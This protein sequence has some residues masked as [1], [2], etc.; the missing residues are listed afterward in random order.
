MSHWGRISVGPW[1]Y[2]DMGNWGPL[3][4][5]GAESGVRASFTHN[6]ICSAGAHEAP[7]PLM[8]VFVERE[9]S[10]VYPVKLRLPSYSS[11]ARLK[12]S[13]SIQ[14]TQRLSLL[15]GWRQCWT[16]LE[17]GFRAPGT[18]LPL[19]AK[20]TFPEAALRAP[21][22]QSPQWHLPG[23]CLPGV[24]LISC[25]WAWC[26]LPVSGFSCPGPCGAAYWCWMLHLPWC[27][28]VI[29]SAGGHPMDCSPP[30]SS[31]YGISQ[32]R[33]L[34]WVA[35]PSSRGCS[36]PRDRTGGSCIAGGLFTIWATRAWYLNSQIRDWT[37]APCS[38]NVES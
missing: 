12:R 3:S 35:K 38:E 10:R 25:P 31:A 23:F 5:V 22:L 28:W 8:G 15:K 36:P 19:P 18:T 26:S 7:S 11:R 2:H 29:C 34:E 30:G 27:V 6:L 33:I 16:K 9:F 32:A 37:H 4:P 14:L 1:E 21:V 17:L 24:T 13:P 20:G